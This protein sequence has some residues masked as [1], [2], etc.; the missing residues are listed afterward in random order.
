MPTSAEDL[1][2]GREYRTGLPILSLEHWGYWGAVFHP[3]YVEA[4]WALQDDHVGVLDRP[5]QE[6][7]DQQHD[8]SLTVTEWRDDWH[9]L[10]KTYDPDRRQP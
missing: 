6:N 3:E 8:P 2:R 10:R 7:F 4:V 9:V 1:A 5:S